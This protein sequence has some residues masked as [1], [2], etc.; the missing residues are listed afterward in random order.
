MLAAYN[1]KI[2]VWNF[3]VSGLITGSIY[4]IPLGIR[5]MTAAGL[6]GK[7]KICFQIK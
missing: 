1:D 3:I 7:R 2:Q 5:A 4:R 6:V